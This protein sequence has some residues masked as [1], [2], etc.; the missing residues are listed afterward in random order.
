MA[1]DHFAI[2]MEIFHAQ[3]ETQQQLL[4][5]NQ[6]RGLEGG[7]SLPTYS[8]KRKEDVLDFVKTVNREANAGNWPTEQKM[9]PAKGALREIAA[10]W[11]WLH[12]AE[13]PQDWVGW[14]TA[15]CSTFRKRYTFA[16][17]KS[18]VTSR[19][20]LKDET[21]PQYTLTK[22]K[23][24]RHCPYRMT[25]SDFIPYLIQGI[26]HRQFRTVLLQNPPLTITT[27]QNYGL[28]EQNSGRAPDRELAQ[29]DALIE[30]QSQEMAEIKKEIGRARRFQPYD[31]PRPQRSTAPPNGERRCYRY[32]Q[33]GHFKWDCPLEN[34]GNRAGNDKAGPL[35]QARQ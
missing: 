24:R 12:D 9:R 23:L 34:K 10:E 35:G 5:K 6:Q 28:L 17:W 7:P 20:Q 30:K 2:M 4:A 18:M 3:N 27:T 14:S 11:R 8:G 31:Q 29:L 33:V 1:E 22:D 26:W 32:D 25:E 15:L 13:V 16:E 21:E 19:V